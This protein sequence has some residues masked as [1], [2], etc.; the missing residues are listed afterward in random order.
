MHLTD[1]KGVVSVFTIGYPKKYLQSMAVKVY[2]AANKLNLKLHFSC[3]SRLQIDDFCLDADT[4][5]EIKSQNST[6]KCW[7]DFIL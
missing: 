5:K 3:R 1:N 4:I 6:T 7:T 2:M